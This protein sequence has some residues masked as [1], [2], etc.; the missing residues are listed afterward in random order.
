[1]H[2]NKTRV[3]CWERNNYLCWLIHSNPNYPKIV[4]YYCLIVRTHSTNVHRF[5]FDRYV[6]T[7][8]LLP[9]DTTTTTRKR[10]SLAQTLLFI[11]A[12]CISTSFAEQMWS[13]LHVLD[14]NTFRSSTTQ[15]TEISQEK[16]T[17]EVT[18]S[19]LVFILLVVLTCHWKL[20]YLGVSINSH[21]TMCGNW[22]NIVLNPKAFFSNVKFLSLLKS[23]EQPEMIDRYNSGPF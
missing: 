14:D 12:Y 16:P 19:P 3:T 5:W 8:T 11:F 23:K 18:P 13:L 1:M 6:R 17:W 7:N 4:S 21:E 2:D 10:E 15:F 20:C 9:C 22:D